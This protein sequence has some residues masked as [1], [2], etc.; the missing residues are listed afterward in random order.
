MGGVA[1]KSPFVMQTLAD[2]LNMPI[3]ITRS[4]QSCALGASIFAATAAGL[5]GSVQEAK[6]AMGSGFETTYQPDKKRAERY[7]GM[8]KRYKS[9]GKIIENR[10]KETSTE[11]A[12]THE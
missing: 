11:R 5:Y 7:A 9:F 8:Y 1:K 4:E 6:E 3:K 12:V 10:T 2:I